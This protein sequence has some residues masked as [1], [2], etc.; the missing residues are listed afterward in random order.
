MSFMNDKNSK[1]PRTVPWGT[2]DITG[3]H[4]D[5]EP[6]TTTRCDRFVRKFSI[7]SKSESLCWVNIIMSPKEKVETASI[8][9]EFL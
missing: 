8:H 9:H 4:L 3:A 1:G 2:P 5:V 7:Q 6:S